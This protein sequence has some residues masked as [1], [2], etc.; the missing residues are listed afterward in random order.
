[1]RGRRR[2][3]CASGDYRRSVVTK[4]LAKRTIVMMMIVMAM[5]GWLRTLLGMRSA[6]ADV[7]QRPIESVSC[8]HAVRDRRNDLNGHR[9][10]E[11]QSCQPPPGHE[12]TNL[13]FENA[14]KR[15]AIKAK[16]CPYRNR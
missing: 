9:Q 6:E 4:A 1:M 7:A 12:E 11:K 16:V 5:S 8:G 14:P 15:A 2:N 3:A 13:S 10:H